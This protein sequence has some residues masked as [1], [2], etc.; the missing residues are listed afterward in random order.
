M[1]VKVSLDGEPEP[2]AVV[3]TPEGVRA[4][5][6]PEA[7][8]KVNLFEQMPEVRKQIFIEK[9]YEGYRK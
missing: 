4:I 5:P 8:G 7:K 2:I 1:A 6:L 3:S 9:L